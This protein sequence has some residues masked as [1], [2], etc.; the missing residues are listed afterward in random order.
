M[1]KIVLFVF[2]I[3]FITSFYSCVNDGNNEVAPPTYCDVLINELHKHSEDYD[4][5][6]YSLSDE[7][8]KT[9]NELEKENWIKEGQECYDEYLI[10][11]GSDTT[12]TN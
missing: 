2:S 4:I 7:Y 10:S 1:K 11:Y 3:L 5:E 6:L 8:F 12:N 9:L